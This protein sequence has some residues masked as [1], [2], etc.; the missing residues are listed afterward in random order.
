MWTWII[1]SIAVYLISVYSV[2]KWTQISHSKGGIH[3]NFS[4]TKTDFF[5]CILPIINT[6]FMFYLW[7]GE[8]PRK[9]RKWSYNKL[10][11]VKNDT[12]P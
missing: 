8:Y 5:C 4:I 6:L 10:F 2:Y 11:R 3:S 12:K 9:R 7:I 1:I